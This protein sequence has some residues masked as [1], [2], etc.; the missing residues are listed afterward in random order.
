MAIELTAGPDAIAKVL[1]DV[2]AASKVD[3]TEVL[4]SRSEAA[5]TRYT[6]NEIHENVIEGDVSLSIR[7]VVGKRVGVASTSR[8]DDRAIAD[9]LA[10]AAS[11]ARLSPEDPLFPGLPEGGPEPQKLQNAHDAATAAASPDDRAAAVGRIA[12]TMQRNQ[13]HAAGFV[14]TRSDV[15]AIANS[16]GT[17]RYFE[18]TD[19]SVNIKAIGDDSSG[20]AEGF[21]RALGWIDFDELAAVAAK[22]AIDGRNPEP[23]APGAYTVILEPPAFREFLGYLSWAGFG[24][25]SLDDGSSFIAGRIGE[26]VMGQNVTIRDDFTHPLSPGIPFDFEGVA[27]TT[28]PIIDAGVAKDVVYD[29]YYAAKMKHANTGH[30][31]PAPNSY[32]PLPLNIVV[33]KG[34][35]ST[36]DLIRSVEHGVLVSRTWYIRL[37]DQKKML[38]TGMT[39]DGLF[40]IERGVV[41]RGLKNMRFN[42]SIV[43]ALGRCEM[44][45]ELRR[46]EGMV[47]PAVRIDGFHFTS[48][49][50]F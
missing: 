49:T 15:V 18:S 19:A 4:F 39:R 50:T 36:A 46:S 31:L 3:E 47:L 5:L 28:V 14:A 25:Q 48:G 45:D 9:T 38:I 17:R 16:K 33:D 24:A 13:L 12:A 44:S 1:S 34:K 26:Q 35:R 37:V 23:L 42:E 22:K 20:Y 43:D 2:I 21:A 10:R 7:A 29:S 11:I 8:L 27:R 40:L 6:R 30:A 41:T 32:G